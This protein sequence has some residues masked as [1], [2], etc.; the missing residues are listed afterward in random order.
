MTEQARRSRLLDEMRDHV[1]TDPGLILEDP[2]MMKALIAANER[3]FGENIVDLRGVA[4]KRLETRLDRLEETHRTV[5]AAAYENLAGAN[6]I[7]RAVLLMLEPAAFTAFLGVMGGPVADTLRVD[8]LRIVL[9]SHEATVNP[10]LGALSSVVQMV[11]AGFAADYIGAGRKLPRR[12]T[13]RQV[14]DLSGPVHGDKAAH[15]RSEAVMLIDLGE[16]RLPAMLVL[17]S[18]DPHQFRPVQGTDLLVFLASV[19]ERLMRRWL[20]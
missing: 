12:V 3:V 16:G 17:G 18:E 10:G 13:L 11:P 7:Q 2:E 1:L 9:E 14:S 6:I 5:I 8:S 19:F 20:A 15:I 4:M